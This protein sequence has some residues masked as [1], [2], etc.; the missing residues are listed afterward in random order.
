MPKK[1]RAANDAKYI[2]N[3]VLREKPQPLISEPL[4]Q[5]NIQVIGNLSHPVAYPVWTQC[6]F[7]IEEKIDGLINLCGAT[8]SA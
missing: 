8:V 7:E 1:T 5:I 2:A 6:N 4:R 3:V